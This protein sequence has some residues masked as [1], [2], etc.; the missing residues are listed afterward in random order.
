MTIADDRYRALELVRA[1]GGENHLFQAVVIPGEPLSKARPRVTSRGTYTPAHV[2]I[3]ESVL[4]AALSGQRWESNVAVAVLFY[5]STFQRVDIDNMLKLVL[6]AGTKAR[7]WRDDS[8]VTALAGV[9]E[10]DAVRPRTI[11]A[12][13]HHQSTLGRGEA[14]KLACITCGEAFLPRKGRS[15]KYCSAACRR[16]RP[17]KPCVQCGAEYRPT[18]GTQ[19]YCSKRCSRAAEWQREKAKGA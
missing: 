13:A 1:I 19:R 9:L 3:A 12:T 17:P 15:Q 18:S 6:D 16:I 11:I 7:I 5:R 2:R 8:Q 14:A 4:A 10:L